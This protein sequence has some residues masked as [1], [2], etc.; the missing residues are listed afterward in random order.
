MAINSDFEYICSVKDA[1]PQLS[2]AS[3]IITKY[4][5]SLLP[6]EKDAL[7]RLIPE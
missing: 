2:H 6:K 3:N 7:I 5:G 4:N 1:Y